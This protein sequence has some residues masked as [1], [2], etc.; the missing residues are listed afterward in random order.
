MPHF[1]HRLFP[2]SRV[3]L[4]SLELLVLDK[5]GFFFSRNPVPLHV[6]AIA[7]IPLSAPSKTLGNVHPEGRVGLLDKGDEGKEERSREVS[8]SP[9][10]MNSLLDFLAGTPSM[11]PTPFWMRPPPNP[12]AQGLLFKEGTKPQQRDKLKGQTLPG[13]GPRLRVQSC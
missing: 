3:T 9:K 5:E 12:G 6:V 4:P 2:L 13:K 1:E 8:V 11:D 10:F 7:P